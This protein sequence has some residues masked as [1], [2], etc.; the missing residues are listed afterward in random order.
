VCTCKTGALTNHD[1]AHAQSVA[2]G[3]HSSDDS[4]RSDID[5]GH[6]TLDGHRV[7]ATWGKTLNFKL[8]NKHTTSAYSL[9]TELSQLVATF[10]EKQWLMLVDAH[11][12]VVPRNLIERL[13][14][15]N[16]TRPVLIQSQPHGV[17]LSRV[18]YDQLL[19]R[20]KQDAA[21]SFDMLIERLASDTTGV[22][23]VDTAFTFQ[24][25]EQQHILLSGQCVPAVIV[26]LAPDIATLKAEFKLTEQVSR[27]SVAYYLLKGGDHRSGCRAH[28]T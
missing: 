20:S 21:N 1:K 27:L 8:L 12:L 3:V 24:Q 13:N 26:P 6:T 5:N 10:P 23:I 2:I 11:S 22:N 7:A 9:Y 14:V 16:P 25:H 4:Y 15:L 28:I 18:L 17:L 19:E